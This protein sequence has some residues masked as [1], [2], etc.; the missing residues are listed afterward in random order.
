M[1]IKMKKSIA[2]FW[3]LLN[4]ASFVSG[5]QP[6]QN[7]LKARALRE[8]GKPDQAIS[9]ITGSLSASTDVRLYSERAEAYMQK[10]DYTNAINDLSEANRLSPASGEYGL[11]RIYAL[12]GD[13]STALY[14]LELNMKSSFKRPEKEVL[15]DDAF[16]SLENRAEWRLFWKKEWYSEEEKGMSEIEYYISAGKIDDAKTVLGRL[17]ADNESA[18]EVQYAEA[19]INI[20]SSNYTGAIKIL[21]GLCSANPENEK[22][23]R[24]LAKA[25]TGA[26][27]P[28]GASNTYTGLL[29]KGVAD[30]D[31]L[32]L[33]AECYRK[34]GEDGKA[35]ADIRQYLDLYPENKTALSMAGKEEAKSGDNLQAMEY[36]SKNLKLHPNDPQCYIDRANSYFVAKSWDMAIDDYSMSLDLNPDNPDVWMNKGIALLSK[37]MKDDAC[38]DFRKALSLGNK[39]VSDYISRNCIK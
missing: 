34:T 38:H 20:A 16:N 18:T 7:I 22:Y 27:D 30:A 12:K 25:Q 31:L 10:R 21:S 24:A 28:S 1:I 37:G 32:L 26:S 6:V 35:L 3:I 4:A 33:R 11:A 39:K 5:Q 13:V 19:L 15:L 29:N 9:L 14:H 8:A 23:M 36:F 17:K 2:L